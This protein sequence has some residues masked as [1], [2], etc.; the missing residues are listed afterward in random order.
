[1]V[2]LLKYDIIDV[3]DIMQSY[4]ITSNTIKQLNDELRKIA[5]GDVIETI[6]AI[7]YDFKE[8]YEEVGYTDLFSTSKTIVVKNCDFFSASNKE[9]GES[10]KGS[11]ADLIEKIINCDNSCIKLIFVTNQKLDMRK[12]IV[13]LFKARNTLIECPLLTNRDLI[14]IVSKYF[15][16]EGYKISSECASYIVNSCLNNYD[17]ILSECEK[18]KLYYNNPCNIEMNDL[19]GIISVSLESNSFKFIDFIVD[20]NIVEAMR[21][22]DDLMV[23]K[24][25][26]IML[27]ILIARDYRN[28]LLVK[29]MVNNRKST[30]EIG[31]YLGMQ[32]WQINKLITKS[33]RFSIKDL[34][35]KLKELAYIDLKIKQ[36][37]V[38]RF[39]ALEMFILKQ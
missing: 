20:G 35:S 29:E 5:Q 22:Y 38:D 9:E 16:E 8:L 2:I 11:N 3:G 12:K 30:F 23:L 1:M 21:M 36:G 7:N 37:K 39:R 26:P 17:F 28:M 24:T 18:V 27:L 15:K 34:K 6:D 4:L 32:D 10:K 19:V 33:R 31:R 13:K 14:N 25:E